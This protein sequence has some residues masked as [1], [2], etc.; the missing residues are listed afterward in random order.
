MSRTSLLIS[1]L[2]LLTAVSG[3]RTLFGSPVLSMRM[4]PSPFSFAP[5]R[6][7]YFPKNSRWEYSSPIAI[8]KSLTRWLRRSAFGNRSRA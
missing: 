3:K 2:W 5:S 1:P 4:L 7:R 6:E 8:R